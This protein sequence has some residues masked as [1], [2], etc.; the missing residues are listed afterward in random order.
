M[1]GGRDVG[2]SDTLFVVNM[3]LGAI[4]FGVLIAGAAGVVPARGAYFAGLFYLLYLMCTLFHRM[5]A[6]AD[7]AAGHAARKE[8]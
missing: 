5:V 1:T 6:M 3:T 2:L 7:A 8:P 4:A